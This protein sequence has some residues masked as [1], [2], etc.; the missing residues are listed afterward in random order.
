MDVLKIDRT[1]IGGLGRNKEVS[2]IVQSIIALAKR[3]GAACGGGWREEE[4]QAAAL[5]GLHCDSTRD[6]ISSA[7]GRNPGPGISSGG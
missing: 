5:R 1:F 6:S 4:Q 7:A 3:P 2:E